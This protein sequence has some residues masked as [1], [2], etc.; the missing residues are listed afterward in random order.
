MKERWTQLWLAASKATPEPRAAVRVTDLALAVAS[1]SRNGLLSRPSRRDFDG[2]ELRDA[3]EGIAFFPLPRLGESRK[4]W[5]LIAA[6][7]AAAASCVAGVSSIDEWTT[8]SQAADPGRKTR[9]SYATPAVLADVL[10]QRSLATLT[11]R[12]AVRVVDP[13]AGTG[14]LLLAALRVLTAGDTPRKVESAIYALH[15]VESDPAARELCCLLIWIAGSTGKGNLHRIAE[16]IVVDNA[17]TRDWWGHEG[18]LFDAVIMNPPWESLRHSVDADDPQDGIRR[19]TTRRLAQ[20]GDGA[21]GLP[22]LFSAQGRGDR[23]LYKAFLE[24]APHLLR[25]GGRL[26]AL[27]PSAFASDYGMTMLRQ[28]YLDQF[29]LESWTSFENLRGLFPIDGRFKFGILVG[30]R[31]SKGTHAISLRSFASAPEHA[32]KA[33]VRVQRA[34]LRRL[35]GPAQMFPEIASDREAAILSQIFRRGTPFFGD[36]VFGR[37]KYARELDLTI[38]RKRGRFTHI[39]KVPGV[40]MR[41]DGTLV[42]PKGQSFVPVIEGRMV[43]Q[44]DP[45]Q[46]SWRSGASRTAKWTPN[47]SLPLSACRPQ[48]IALAGRRHESPRIA[49]CDVTSATNTRTVHATW[50]PQGWQC[51]NTAPVLRFEDNESAMAALAVLNSLVFDW[52]VRRIVAGLHLNR[53]YLEALAWPRLGRNEV[54]QLAEAAYSISLLNPR[55][56]AIAPEMHR[57]STL[58]KGE[59]HALIERT[60][61]AGYELAPDMLADIFDPSSDVRRGFWR[62]F[63]NEPAS[64]AVVRSTLAQYRSAPA[65]VL[66]ASA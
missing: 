39:D 16:N 47:G 54:R 35:G 56:A 46:K 19:E 18:Q 12:G 5:D 51:G 52:I 58:A 53:F 6:R 26:A 63:R 55:V 57:T 50:V 20:I 66:D 59:A 1:A 49:L 64:A 2:M 42:D 36:S 17:L 29:A 41:G 3:I 61:A 22:P 44:Y 30:E 4:V 32:T 48:F 13:S 28:R 21:L 34:D 43:G 8:C 62:Y 24:L 27:I 60:V 33:H 23:N 15:G 45:F 14:A 25:P 38:D 31:S 65:V 40:Q 10:A 37:V 7:A 11:G 9:G